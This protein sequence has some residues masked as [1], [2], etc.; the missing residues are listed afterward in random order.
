VASASRKRRRARLGVTGSVTR[1]LLPV[2]LLGDG[3]AASKIDAACKNGAPT[4][5]LPKR[6][7]KP[8]QIAVSA[9]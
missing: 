6:E 3:V 4:V 9:N 7:T 5:R 2:V 1:G 8:R